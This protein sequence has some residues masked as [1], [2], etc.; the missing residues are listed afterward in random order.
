MMP[1][2]VRPFTASIPEADLVD[3]R[4]RLART[5]WSAAETVD[6]WSQG[7][8]LA[9]LKEV[10]DTWATSYDWR[11]FEEQVNG[12]DQFLTEIDGVDIHFIHARSPEPNARPLIVTHGWPGSIVEYVD[13]IEALRDPV[14]HGGSAEDAFHVVVPSLPGFGFSG[15]PTGTGWDVPKVGEAWVELMKRLGY[16]RFLAQGGDWGSIITTH[17]GHSQTQAVEGIHINLAIC[18]PDAL[19]ALGEPTEEEMGQLGLLQAYATEGNG[20]S[21]IQSTRPQT[22]GYGLTDSPVGQ[23][24]WILEK[25]QAWTDNDGHPESAVSRTKIL[26]NIALYWLTATATSSAQMYWESLTAVFTDFTPATVPTAYS[27]FPK[28]L[29]LFTERWAR[30]RYPDLRYFS[31]PAKGGHFAATE[32]PELFVEEVRAGFR[33]LRH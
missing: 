10:C 22:V 3:L 26:D 20:Y 12:F 15:K 17:M 16:D 4:E 5:R 31:V 11:A 30:T 28:D 23:C 33:A 8:P 29:F 18:S 9:Y 13:V 21:Q 27:C 32:Q 24:A 7:V 19:F 14:A 25:F 6:D 2:A 1:N